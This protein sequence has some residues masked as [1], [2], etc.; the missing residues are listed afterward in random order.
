MWFHL[1]LIALGFLTAWN[2]RLCF[3][4]HKYEAILKQ[5]QFGDSVKYTYS[6]FALLLDFFSQK[7]VEAGSIWHIKLEITYKFRTTGHLDAS[8]EIFI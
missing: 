1:L 5:V 6:P 4:F 3:H 2:A 7:N 8:K